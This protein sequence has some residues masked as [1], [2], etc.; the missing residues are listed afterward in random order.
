MKETLIKFSGVAFVLITIFNAALIK[1]IVYQELMANNQL[2]LIVRALWYVEIALIIGFAILLLLAKSNS[3][4]VIGII[5]LTFPVLSFISTDTGTKFTT[6]IIA[7]LEL[8]I[9]I[10]VPIIA[11]KQQQFKNKVLSSLAV[12]SIIA[13][14]S[15]DNLYD[16][17]TITFFKFSEGEYSQ[18]VS[19]F[20]GLTFD[21][22]RV[23]IVYIPF[24][25]LIFYLA[26][27]S[28]K[29]GIFT[30]LTKQT[31]ILEP[32]F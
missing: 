3:H 26:L 16:A 13:R 7:Y 23:V 17:I 5:L 30:I 24:L 20:K 14:L 27:N 11:A 10:L 2:L 4:K 31:G 25:L 9:F 19:M 1:I 6:L 12:L 29:L 18:F 15:I 21:D 22:A 32:A 28:K 8:A